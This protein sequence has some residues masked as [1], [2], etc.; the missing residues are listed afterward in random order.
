MEKN[1]NKFEELKKFIINFTFLRNNFT[2]KLHHYNDIITVCND[3]SYVIK[4]EKKI[5]TKGAHG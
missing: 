4:V 5:L 3:S 2:E 1:K